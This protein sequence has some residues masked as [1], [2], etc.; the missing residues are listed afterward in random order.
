MSRS[1]RKPYLGNTSSSKLWKRAFNQKVRRVED[2]PN[3]MQY[4]KFNEVWDSSM[5]NCHV[6]IDEPRMRRK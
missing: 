6:Y 1:Y 3:G 5:E 4:K 2:V